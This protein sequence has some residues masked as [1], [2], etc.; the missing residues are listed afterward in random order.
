MIARLTWLCTS[1]RKRRVGCFPLG[2]RSVS[3]RCR[4]SRKLECTR[5]EIVLQQGRYRLVR[6]AILNLTPHQLPGNVVLLASLFW[7][8][9]SCS[10][11]GLVRSNTRL[12][13]TG[14]S[15]RQTRAIRLGIISTNL[16]EEQ[17]LKVLEASPTSGREAGAGPEGSGG[18][19]GAP[20]SANGVMLGIRR[21]ANEP[22]R[23]PLADVGSTSSVGEV[24][25]GRHSQPAA[26][27]TDPFTRTLTIRSSRPGTP[28]GHRLGAGGTSSSA[29]PTTTSRSARSPRH[30]RRLL[31]RRP[32]VTDAEFGA[33]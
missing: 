18:R 31:D 28:R 33:S 27:R 6:G 13:S 7:L 14:R 32:T 21:V 12:A 30:C 17:L 8:D 25:L 5:S 1:A 11:E 16:P 19:A 10:D 22:S 23:L 26:S 4:P 9:R 29:R 2:V 24:G 15:R 3:C 20:D